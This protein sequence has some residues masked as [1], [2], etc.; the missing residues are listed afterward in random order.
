MKGN[1]VERRYIHLASHKGQMNRCFVLCTLAYQTIDI[2]KRA[3]PD[4]LGRRSGDKDPNKSQCTY[5]IVPWATLSDRDAA[6]QY[7]RI[8]P[9]ND[10][11]ARRSSF[12]EHVSGDPVY[13]ACVSAPKE[14]N[15]AMEV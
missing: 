7:W 1:F 13:H 5:L 9:G 4:L 12:S 14:L 15:R 8:D 2:H 3:P 11:A 6:T 10:G